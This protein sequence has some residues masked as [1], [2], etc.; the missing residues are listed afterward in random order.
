MIIE[1]NFSLF[2]SNEK[3]FP[4]FDISNGV[5][6]RIMTKDTSHS[7]ALVIYADVASLIRSTKAAVRSCFSAIIELPPPV[8]EYQ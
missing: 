6:Y 2:T 3:L 8:R 4:S 7:I 5:R 1:R